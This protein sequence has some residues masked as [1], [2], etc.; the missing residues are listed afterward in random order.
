MRSGGAIPPPQK[1]YLSDTGAI[2]YEN[3]ANWCDTPLCDKNLER[4]L[5]DMGGVSRTGPLSYQKSFQTPVEISRDLIN[6]STQRYQL[7]APQKA[8]TLRILRPTPPPLHQQ[9]ET[10]REWTRQTYGEKRGRKMSEGFCLPFF[11]NS[12]EKKGHLTKN[13]PPKMA[14][15]F[16]PLQV[17]L[18]SLGSLCM[19]QQKHLVGKQKELK[20]S[21]PPKSYIK[22]KN[23]LKNSF[24]SRF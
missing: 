1:G 6:I 15:S 17:L 20:S 22:D 18:S 4:V 24:P 21:T 12:G 23:Q 19:I 14:S 16:V 3:K 2:P 11:S 5:R 8:S 9:R 13:F 7:G 10:L